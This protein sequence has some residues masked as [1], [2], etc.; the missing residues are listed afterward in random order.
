MTKPHFV[1]IP[2]PIPADAAALLPLD[3][4]R[5]GRPTMAGRVHRA[6]RDAIISLRLRP[7]DSLSEADIA[8]QLG[9]SRQPVREAFIKLA[10][11]GFVAI[12]PQKGTQVL[13]ISSREVGNARFIRQTIEV[14]IAERA[15]LTASPA[16]IERLAANIA[17]QRR[18]GYD[19]GAYDRFLALDDE[20]HQAIAE[21]AGFGSI[22]RVVE[23]LKGQMDRVRYL[24]IAE[25][26]PVPRLI[27][28]HAQVV[29]GI[30]ER[31]PEKAGAAMYV[32]LS[33]MLNSLPVLAA[34]HAELFSD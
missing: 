8:R 9:T 34:R 27:D 2:S 18:L 17:A 13:K 4:G 3:P 23:D 22:W 6:L 16:D 30:A 32:H 7:G 15:A 19:A 1:P 21:V 29:E 33:E 26:T 25:A 12:V 24:S 28:Q 20:L 31:N 14:A 10:E 5:A 11:T